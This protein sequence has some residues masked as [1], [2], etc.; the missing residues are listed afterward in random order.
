MKINIR[1]E[2]EAAGIYF[3]YEHWT[4]L[5]WKCLLMTTIKKIHYTNKTPTKS[6]YLRCNN[7]WFILTGPWND[8]E[9]SKVPSTAERQTGDTH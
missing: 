6:D 7:C 2:K 5:D 4:E 8:Y 1:N 3:K 9:W